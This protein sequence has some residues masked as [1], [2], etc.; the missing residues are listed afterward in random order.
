MIYKSLSLSFMFFLL[1]ACSTAKP[2]INLNLIASTPMLDV[3]GI[4]DSSDFS[5]SSLNVLTV[6]PVNTNTIIK[7]LKLD[8]DM[9]GKI[10]RIISEAGADPVDRNLA[11]T[12]MDEIDLAEESGDYGNYEGPAISDLV[13]VTKLTDANLSYSFEIES[14]YKTTNHGVE[15]SEANCN[16]KASVSGY[17]KVLSMPHMKLI[18]TIPFEGIQSQ[19]I[20]TLDSECPIT[21]TQKAN[22]FSS[23]ITDALSSNSTNFKLH[24]AVAARA[25]IVD[26]KVDEKRTYFKTTLKRSLGAK[27]GEGVRLY[28]EDE[29]SNELLFVADG[30]ITANEYITD[31]FSYIYLLDR[32]QIPL[33]RKGMIV[34]LHKKCGILCKAS[35]ASSSFNKFISN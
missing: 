25:F 21:D 17:I 33:I 26:K 13:L 27:E 31:K 35:N 16:F 23:A 24:S 12:L 10:E 7:Q 22:M 2:K 14:T 34:K 8:K 32:K 9:P 6:A 18:E 4:T 28:M 29:D 20:D 15:I 5:G 30:V 19:D 1:A 3:A 11:F